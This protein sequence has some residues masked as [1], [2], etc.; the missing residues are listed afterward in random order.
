MRDG[1]ESRSE[2][3]ALGSTFKES[4]GVQTGSDSTDT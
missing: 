3:S 2:G 1:V 4:D